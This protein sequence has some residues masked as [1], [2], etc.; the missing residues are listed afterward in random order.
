MRVY[1]EGALGGP[2]LSLASTIYYVARGRLS[3]VAAVPDY[4]QVFAF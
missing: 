3:M 4:P 2:L 1:D